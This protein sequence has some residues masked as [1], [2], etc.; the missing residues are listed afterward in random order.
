MKTKK[1]SLLLCSPPA[2]NISRSSQP[3]GPTRD[4][5]DVYPKNWEQWF[6]PYWLV[7]PRPNE[8]TEVWL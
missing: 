2:D 7:L 6:Y 8:G 4:V 1:E 3:P 5:H